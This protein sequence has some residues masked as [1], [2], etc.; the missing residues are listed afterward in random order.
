MTLGDGTILKVEEL[1]HNPTYWDLVQAG[2]W[3]AH[4]VAAIQQLLGPGSVMLEIGGWIGLTA[5]MAAAQ[6]AEV[7]SYEPDPHAL[8][9]FRRHM[10]MN[11]R[12]AERITLHDQ[13]VATRSG[14]ASIWSSALGDSTAS[15]LK[16]RGDTRRSRR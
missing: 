5:S 9:K 2:K 3:E 11:P 12:L 10:E 16:S 7:H 4:T 13:A 8:T 1:P 15:L 14:Q 6:G